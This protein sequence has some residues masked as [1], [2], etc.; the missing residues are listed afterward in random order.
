MRFDYSQTHQPT[1][2]VENAVTIT[3]T[4]DLDFMVEDLSLLPR[5]T[6]AFSCFS[7]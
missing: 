2:Y 5:P 6:Q 7:R 4:K 3:Q 1:D